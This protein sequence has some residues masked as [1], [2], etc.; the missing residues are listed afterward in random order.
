MGKAHHLPHQVAE[1][2]SKIQLLWHQLQFCYPPPL[3]RLGPHFLSAH[4]GNTPLT[5]SIGHSQGL[6]GVSGQLCKEPVYPN[7]G[8][9]RKTTRRGVHAHFPTVGP[10]YIPVLAPPF[11]DRMGQ[12]WFSPPSGQGHVRRN[13]ES[14]TSLKGRRGSPHLEDQLL[15]IRLTTHKTT[16][17]FALLLTL[18]YHSKG[19][20]GRGVFGTQAALLERW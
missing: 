3:P 8:P 9:S 19:E 4:A 13:W 11:L 10:S 17:E 18:L 15:Y 16:D 7:P 1:S 6:M 20:T 2:W 5:L 12:C 14:Y